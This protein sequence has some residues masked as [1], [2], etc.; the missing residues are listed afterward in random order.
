MLLLLFAKIQAS[1][2]F[3]CSHNSLDFGI[4]RWYLAFI[5]APY[6]DKPDPVVHSHTYIRLFLNAFGFLFFSPFYRFAILPFGLLLSWCDPVCVREHILNALAVWLFSYSFFT[7]YY[8]QKIYI[9]GHECN[10]FVF[11]YFCCCCCCSWCEH[12]C[13]CI[14]TFFP[15]NSWVPCANTLSTLDGSPNVINPKPLQINKVKRK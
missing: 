10:S 9:N 5:F 12:V 7:C 13:K 11:F 1:L 14:L 6:A 4:C 8:L 2:S 3:D 15:S